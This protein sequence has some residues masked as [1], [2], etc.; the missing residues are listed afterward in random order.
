MTYKEGMASE[1]D[2]QWMDSASADLLSLD[3][4]WEN[5]TSFIHSVNSY[6]LA[7]MCKAVL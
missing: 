2:S 4:R 3:D 6:W 7:T 1:G 5:I